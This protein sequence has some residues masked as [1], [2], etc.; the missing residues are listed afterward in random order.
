MKYQDKPHKNTED[1][2]SFITTIREK[3]QKEMDRI[4]KTINKKNKD[5]SEKVDDN[6]Q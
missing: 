5:D 2:K 6:S 3:E 4:K 1:K